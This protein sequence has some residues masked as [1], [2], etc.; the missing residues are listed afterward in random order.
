MHRAEALRLVGFAHEQLLLRAPVFVGATR[1]HWS[2]IIGSAAVVLTGANLAFGQ[3]T[4]APPSS[5]ETAPSGQVT[6]QARASVKRSA[7]RQEGINKNMRG[8][9]LQ[10]YVAVCVL[11]ARLAC[12]KQAVAEK[13]RPPAR[14]DFIRKCMGES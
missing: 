14:R 10:D 7:C 4:P 5:P 13:I 12:L 11:E 2:S 6:P 9:D 8:A 3:T 1:M